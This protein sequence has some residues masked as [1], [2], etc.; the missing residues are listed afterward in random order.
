M[1]AIIVIAGLMY[2]FGFFPEEKPVPD[3]PISFPPPPKIKPDQIVTVVDRNRIQPIDFPQF[4]AVAVAATGMKAHERVIGLVING[5]ARAYPINILSVHEVVNDVV[6]GEPVAVTWCPLC[7]SALVFSRKLEGF[8]EPLTFGV[9]GALLHNTLVM[10]D[11]QTETLWSQLYGA[12]IDGEFAGVT[13][14]VYP[15]I[16]TNWEVWQ[17]QYP[18]SQV[19]SKE[20]TCEQFDCLAFQ[21]S[22][23]SGYSTDPYRSYYQTS[24]FGVYDGQIPR[25]LEAGE[26]KRRVLGVRIGDRER[27]YPFT[28]LAE[29]TLIN[30]QIGGL[31]VLVVFDPES[32]T[33]LVFI[34]LTAERTL[35]FR[36]A[37]DVTGMVVDDETESRWDALTG[38]AVGGELRGEQ[39][40][41]LVATA[42]FEYGWFDYFP[43]SEVYLP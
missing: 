5:E 31:P 13:L 4:E 28:V 23:Q 18:D 6:G 1:I 14:S 39:L 36:H 7:F 38:E 40:E 32:Q 11:R 12:A 3:Q 42:A 17:S 25:G 34:R 22:A 26:A 33:G 41:S 2:G 16:L 9:S 21:I 8:S 37:S 19:L 20:L 15:S 29:H 24:E 10:Y 35:T 27:A 43:E 30:D